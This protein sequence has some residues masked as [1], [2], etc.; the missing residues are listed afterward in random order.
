[1][2]SL[3]NSHEK[4]TEG[5][6]WY[7]D[8]VINAADA[9]NKINIHSHGLEKNFY[10]PDLQLCLPT[11]PEYAAV[12]FMDIIDLIREGRRFLGKHRLQ[13]HLPRIHRKIY[14]CNG[15]KKI[16]IADHPAG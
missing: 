5:I 14:C 3:E 13:R 12:I 10:H 15:R 2:E 11:K 7:L 1:M 6:G 9:P 4:K 16:G 8:Y